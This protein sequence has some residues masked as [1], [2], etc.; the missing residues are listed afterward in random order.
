METSNNSKKY[1]LGVCVLA[2]SGLLLGCVLGYLGTHFVL[3]KTVL[4]QLKDEGYIYTGDAT[5]TAED[6]VSGK[7]AYVNGNLV[8][9]TVVRFDTSDAT[10]KA[11]YILQG[12]TA[13]V[14]GQLV[15]G[16]I[17][18]IPASEVTPTADSK[19]L[20]GNVYLSGDIVI[21]GDKNLIASNIKKGITIFGVTGTY[22]PAAAEGGND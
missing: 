10:A 20:L 7:A 18:V 17:Q 5:A 13:Y 1:I 16:T 22:E 12:K 6:I 2:L 19:N 15:V 14:N 21:K 4:N 9:G 3:E 11:D 8:N